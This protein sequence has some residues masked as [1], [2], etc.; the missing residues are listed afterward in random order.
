MIRYGKDNHTGG[1][2]KGSMEKGSPKN[3]QIYSL[4]EAVVLSSQ[5]LSRAAHNKTCQ[6]SLNHRVTHDN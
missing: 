4:K 1:E 2:I 5:G 3:G 6:R